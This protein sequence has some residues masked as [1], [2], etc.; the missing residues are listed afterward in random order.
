[1]SATTSTCNEMIEWV[2]CKGCASDVTLN[3]GYA[4]EKRDAKF[5]WQRDGEREIDAF[6]DIFVLWTEILIQYARLFP[7]LN[8]CDIS[9][10]DIFQR[11]GIAMFIYKGE[12]ICNYKEELCALYTLLNVFILLYNFSQIRNCKIILL[13]H[14]IMPLLLA[15]EKIF[16]VSISVIHMEK[17]KAICETFPECTINEPDISMQRYYTDGIFFFVLVIHGYIKF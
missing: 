7:A 2:R 6:H 12:N 10:L 15:T 14:C 8:F 13:H 16:Y 5:G 1:M 11:K 3:I 9:F 4:V 17:T